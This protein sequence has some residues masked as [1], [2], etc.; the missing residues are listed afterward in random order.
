MAIMIP[1]VPHEYAEA[2]QEGILYSALSQLSDDYYV[3]HS[4]KIATV[5]AD[6]FQENE[7]DFVVFNPYKGLICIEAKA[8]RVKYQNGQWFYGN[9]VPMH[10]GGP[11]RQADNIKWKLI[12][13]I[14]DR[15]Y[16]RIIT[17]CKFYHAVWFP[18]LS[19]PD[20]QGIDL[21][22]ECVIEQI[23]TKESLTNIEEDINRI[24]DIKLFAGKN[25]LIQNLSQNDVKTLI[26]KVLCPHF[27]IFPSTSIDNDIKN[28]VFHHM[29]DEQKHIL[30]FLVEQKTAAINGAAGTGKTM[31]ALEKSRRDA[32]VGEKVLFLCYNNK[33]KQFLANNF[34][35]D[36]ID[37]Y[38]IAGFACK[39]CN[40]ASPDYSMLSELLISASEKNTFQ[41]KHIVIDEGQDF[42]IETIEETD[43]LSL[44]KEIVTDDPI[45]GTFYVF[46]DRLQLV[47]SRRVPEFIDQADCKVTLYKNCR[48]TVNI[49]KTS[50]RPLSERKPILKEGSI[51]GTPARIHYCDNS[52]QVERELDTVINEYVKKGVN[53]IVILTC[54]TENK[55][56][57]YRY[58]KDEKYK[59]GWN[60]TT[61]RKYKGLEAD[62]VILVDFDI[63]SFDNQEA[64]VFYVGASRARLY[65]D[66]I[67]EID[68]S[69]CEKIIREKLSIDRKIRHPKKSLA[70]ALNATATVSQ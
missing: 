37:F 57:I 10:K 24:F 32:D 23:L 3:L 9:D 39:M 7:G 29:L 33:L 48:N 21:P 43:T 16:D 28:I 36:N 4:L 8:G 12:D 35:N 66:I 30:D 53:D 54:K 58:T 44:L 20:V 14:R 19:K 70:T 50:L 41:Y 62:A 65:L 69:T 5:K 26:N 51:V 46:Y 45:N 18:M 22:S 49:A 68:D 67:T 52:S 34:S 2:S 42:G 60:F 25:E 56:V 27:D 13:Y 63:D 61:C 47:Q 1:A 11:F 6:T 15:G 40:S 64:L 59:N 31:V 17:R 38:T 55:S